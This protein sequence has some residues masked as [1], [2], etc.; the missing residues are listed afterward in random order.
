MKKNIILFILSLLSIFIVSA[1]QESNNG[2]QRGTFTDNRDGQK[3]KWVKIG[4]Q[5]WMAENLNYYTS[6][7]WSYNNQT[8]NDALYGRY[9]TWYTAKT[10]CPVGWHLPSDTEWTELTN[11]L[12]G[13]SV[14]GGKLKETGTTHWESPNEGATNETGF[15]AL[16]GNFHTSSDY[17]SN[18]GLFAFFWSSSSSDTDTISALTRLLGWNRDDIRRDENAKF[19]GQS[20]RC[21]A[22]EILSGQEKPDTIIIDENLM[23]IYR[24]SFSGKWN[25]T[26]KF[27]FYY[28]GE[29]KNV[30]EKRSE[31]TALPLNEE[32]AIWFIGGLDM[33]VKSFKS[34]LTALEGIY[35]ICEDDIFRICDLCCHCEEAEMKDDGYINFSFKLS[36]EETKDKLWHSYYE[37]YGEKPSNEFLEEELSHIDYKIEYVF[38]RM[39]SPNNQNAIIPKA[40]GT[41]FAISSKGYLV[42]NYH[43]IENSNRIQVRGINGDLT[44]AYEAEIILSDKANDLA[45]IKTKDNNLIINGVVPFKLNDV[46]QNVGTSIYTLG[47]P[48]LSTMG[49]EIKLTNGIVSART[50]FQGDITSY[51]ITAPVQ[52]GNSGCP[53]FNINGDLIG[54]ISSK[55]AEAENAAYAIKAVY[56]K[57][58]IE[59]IPDKLSMNQSKIIQGTSL[60][61]QVLMIKPF[62]YII[63]VF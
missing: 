25:V 40:T 33:Y 5:F 39:Y 19:F 4:N 38:I 30:D 47:Y 17:I 10:I 29:L 36:T 28:D 42:T 20:V 26:L 58:L 56:L 48:L 3:Y 23:R 7:T 34:K 14:A 35:I 50:G 18:V 61:N 63:E 62:I 41:C 21:V 9:Y 6:G 8:S 2:L 44:T 43:M 60:E 55:N 24:K 52:P 59:L 12:G 37:A 53:L 46:L 15:T 49:E 54:I 27:K 57:Q 31:F 45:I 16:P 32:G 1:Q 22:P 11:Y 51:Q 13:E